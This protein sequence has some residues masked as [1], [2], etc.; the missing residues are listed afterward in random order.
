MIGSGHFSRDSQRQS[1]SKP[2]RVLKF[3]VWLF[4]RMIQ[5]KMKFFLV[6]VLLVCTVCTTFAQQSSS[7]SS[8][9]EDNQF[10]FK[11]ESDHQGL[12]PDTFR[13]LAEALYQ[14]G[15][16]MQNRLQRNFFVNTNITCNDG[17]T[18]GYYIRRHYQSKKW[19]VFLEGKSL[20]VALR[21]NGEL[22]CISE[23]IILLS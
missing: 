19:I 7:S 23:K 20:K 17:S 12:P 8:A 3:H 11:Y 9:P 13:K 22:S 4:C 10:D 15:D 18:S 2:F 21:A 5:P 1:L 16:K 14:R 6:I